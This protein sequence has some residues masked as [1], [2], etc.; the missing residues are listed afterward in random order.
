MASLLRENVRISERITG[1]VGRGRE[2]E[3]ETHTLA[4]WVRPCWIFTH[5]KI[6]GGLTGHEERYARVSY[7]TKKADLRDLCWG[8]PRG[9]VTWTFYSPRIWSVVRMWSCMHF[10]CKGRI[11]P[12]LL[13]LSDVE[14]RYNSTQA[15]QTGWLC[16]TWK[17]GE[18]ITE[19]PS[20]RLSSCLGLSDWH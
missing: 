9:T 3:R 8:W 12:Q 13:L 1:R 18:E 17:K 6:Q 14:P 11:N 16:N 10:M 15:S 7:L 19:N 2:G 5:A 20:P 4:I